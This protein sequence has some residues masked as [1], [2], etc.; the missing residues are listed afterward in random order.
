[1]AFLAEFKKFATRG[2]A[3]DMAVGIVIGGAFTAIVTSIVSNVITPIMGYLQGGVDFKDK[4]WTL[5]APELT[6]EMMPPVIGYGAVI[7]AF[8]NFLIVAFVL[9]LVIRAM[10]RFQR[11]ENAPPAAVPEDVK[12][13]REIRDLL[14]KGGAG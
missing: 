3:I 6:K 10:N 4:S 11:T 1:M 5:P 7:Q 9:F 13:L 14:A 2:N 12:L 8:I